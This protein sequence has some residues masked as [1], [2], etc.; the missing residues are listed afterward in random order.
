MNS[1]IKIS[2]IIATFNRSH[3]ITQTLES[4]KN[5]TFTSFECLIIDDHSKDNSKE[6]IESY[7][8]TDN[9]F[10][11]HLRSSKFKKGLPGCRNFGMTMSNGKYLLFFDDDDLLHYQCLEICMTALSVKNC[12][13]CR[14]GRL[15]FNDEQNQIFENQMMLIDTEIDNTFFNKIM[16]NELPFN[17]CQ[18]IWKFD[19]FQEH[20]FNEELMYAEDWECYLKILFSAFKG[21]NLKNV[22]M[23]A[24]KHRHSNTGEY[25]L[26]NHTRIRGNILAIKSIIKFLN[27]N[28][29]LYF[30]RKKYLFNQLDVMIGRDDLFNFIRSQLN[31][32]EFK[33]WMLYFQIKPIRL[34][35]F[36]MANKHNSK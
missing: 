25:Y 10:K 15:A 31:W 28:R 29:A 20:K 33:F 7:I 26:G 14:F 19:C 2:I 16:K 24:R 4:I 8:A 35:F 11:Y 17:S 36:H 6:I 12:D 22:L 27:Q 13:Y 21:V 9:R 32:L 30:N 18:I 5:Q 3:L 34:F 23:H 1:E